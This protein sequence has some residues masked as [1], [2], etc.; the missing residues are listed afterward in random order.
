MFFCGATRPTMRASI[1]SPGNPASSS[2]RN[3]SLSAGVTAAGAGAAT[4]AKSTRVPPTARARSAKSSLAPSVRSA[5]RAMNDS[6][7]CSSFCLIPRPLA[8]L[9]QLTTTGTGERRAARSASNPARKPCAWMMSGAKWW[10]RRR[11]PNGSHVTGCNWV[12]I[13]HSIA[14]TFGTWS[15]SKWLRVEAGAR[16]AT[17]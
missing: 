2:R 8:W 17:V 7:P 16:T 14:V 5:R 13:A 9:C 1:A 12:L 6:T 3:P 15:S 11:N 10:M 4:G